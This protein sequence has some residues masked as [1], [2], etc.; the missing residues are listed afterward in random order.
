MPLIMY[1]IQPCARECIKCAPPNCMPMV[2]TSFRAVCLRVTCYLELRS[3]VVNV[4][5]LCSVAVCAM[6]VLTIECIDIVLW[7]LPV[8]QCT[9]RSIFCLCPCSFV[10]VM[11]TAGKSYFL[12]PELTSGC[13]SFLKTLVV[14]LVH[15]AHLYVRNVLSSHPIMCIPHTSTLRNVNY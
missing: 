6:S 1:S 13:L 3:K 11:W 8:S 9:T 14:Q 5:S 7:C 15:V 10:P 2:Y 4:F 12:Q